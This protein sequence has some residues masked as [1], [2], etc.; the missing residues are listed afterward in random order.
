[1]T[2]RYIV[3]HLGDLGYVW[4]ASERSVTFTQRKDE[5]RRYTL[6]TARQIAGRIGGIIEKI[7]SEDEGNEQ[8]TR[9]NR[10]PF[11]RT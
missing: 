11:G 5:A 9:D 7:E 6:K 3:V 2:V 1:M 10:S 8:A 4:R